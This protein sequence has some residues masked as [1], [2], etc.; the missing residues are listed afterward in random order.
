MPDL[1]TL[2]ENLAEL[3]TAIGELR[4]PGGCAFDR[5]PE[6]MSEEKRARLAK[7]CGDAGELEKMIEFVRGEL[8]RR[9]RTSAEGRS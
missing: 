1:G 9:T 8:G 7:L 6:E 3:K 2:R 5:K 4:R